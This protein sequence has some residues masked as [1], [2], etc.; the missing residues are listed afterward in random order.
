MYCPF[1]IDIAYLMSLVR[2]IC[3]LLRVMPQH[4]QD[5]VN[6]HM[7]TLNQ[8]WVKQD[9]WNDTIQWLEDEARMDVKHVRIPLDRE[10][11]EIMY[12]PHSVEVKFQTYVL[13][14]VAKI[15]HI[16]GVDW[17]MPSS[18]GW[19]NTNQAM[20]AGDYETMGLIVKKH[21][22]AALRL[23]VKKIV[24]SECGHSFKSTV[25]DGSRWLGWRDPPVQYIHSVQ[26]YHELLNDGKIK[27]ARKIKEPVT[28]QDPCNVVRGGGMGSML[29]DIVRATCEDFRDITPR[30]EHNYCCCSGAGVLHCGPAWKFVRMEGDSIKAD[31]LRET[32]AKI[33]ITPCHSCHKGIDDLIKYFKLGMHAKFVSDVLLE[34]MEIPEELKVG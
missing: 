32:E 11:A 4:L 1:G 13:T 31:Q 6:S 19:D 18:D 33:V 21:F 30:Y 14:T 28:V 9:E 7:A 3:N 20:H 27:I 26:F 5:R 12:A 2:R 24:M 25:Y 8:E 10:G 29:R 16:A 17:T 23:K 34:T 15:F 22:D